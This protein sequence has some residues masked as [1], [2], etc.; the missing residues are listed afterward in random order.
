M[1]EW[2]KVVGE[3]LRQHTQPSKIVFAGD[4]RAD[5]TLHIYVQH[6][7]ATQIQHMESQ[8]IEKIATFLGYR[9]VGKLKIIQRELSQEET[10]PVLEKKPTRGGKKLPKALDD[11][12]DDDLKAALSRLGKHI[13]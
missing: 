2:S 13:S 12:D 7:F 5:G 6:G 4:K 3:E 1:A 9:A 11:I 10:S 8:I